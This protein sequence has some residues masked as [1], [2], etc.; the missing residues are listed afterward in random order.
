[1]SSLSLSSIVGFNQSDLAS[2][3]DV[4]MDVLWVDWQLAECPPGDEW[5]TE[6]H[7]SHDGWTL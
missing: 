5:S 4:W 2:P 1:M 3:T 7:G 6:K